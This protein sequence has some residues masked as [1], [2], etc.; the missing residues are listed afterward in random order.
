[1]TIRTSSTVRIVASGCQNQKQEGYFRTNS[2]AR[3]TNSGAASCCS[4][5]TSAMAFSLMAGKLAEIQSLRNGGI[6]PV[7]RI[8]AIRRRAC[9][10]VQWRRAAGY[11]SG[12]PRASDPTACGAP[13]RRTIPR[14]RC[15]RTHPLCRGAAPVPARGSGWARGIRRSRLRS[16]AARFFR[17]RGGRRSSD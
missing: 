15:H 6:R 5:S 17:G 7:G 12:R 9:A 13:R 8:P 11:R 3:A 2:S 14:L 1:M 10:G 4:G 16:S